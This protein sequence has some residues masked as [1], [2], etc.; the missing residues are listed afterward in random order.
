VPGA[1]TIATARR[2]VLGG[3]GDGKG[4][5]Y[6]ALCGKIAREIMFPKKILS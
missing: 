5:G 4:E 2:V 1:D 6:E 3:G